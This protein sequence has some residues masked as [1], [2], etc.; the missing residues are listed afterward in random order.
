MWDLHRLQCVSEERFNDRLNPKGS[1]KPENPGKEFILKLA[2][3]VIRN[4]N[5]QRDKNGHSYARKAMV[6]TGLSLNFNGKWKEAQLS[7]ELQEIVAKHRNVFEGAPINEA[8]VETESDFEGLND[9]TSVER[10]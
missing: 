6:R 10:P 2:R 8:D 9:R 1:G 5:K 4:V 7:L 3:D